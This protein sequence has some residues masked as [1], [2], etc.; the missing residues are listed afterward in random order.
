MTKL[1]WVTAGIVALFVAALTATLIAPPWCLASDT[2]PA[3]TPKLPSR[4]LI[5]P[6]M[7]AKVT[8]SLTPAPGQGVEVKL[9]LTSPSGGKVDSIPLTIAVYSSSGSMMSRGPSPMTLETQVDASMPVGA[10]GSGASVVKLPLT[11]AP[12]MAAPSPA[13]AIAPTS[14]VD[15]TGKPVP[16]SKPIIIQLN[17]DRTRYQMMISSKLGG[18]T[19]SVVMWMGMGALV[20]N[21]KATTATTAAPTASLAQ[22]QAAATVATLPAIF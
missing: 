1:D 13:P 7:N 2:T 18:K 22:M 10:D 20:K 11:W 9:A 12:A 21:T 19:N 16:V 17:A 6:S 15:T 3:V 8:A 5:I 4:D 14:S